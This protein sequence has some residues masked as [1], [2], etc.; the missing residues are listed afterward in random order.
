[1]SEKPKE[2]TDPTDQFKL[3]T[4]SHKKKQKTD[5]PTKAAE[6][7]RETEASSSPK[8]P[9]V[10]V[11]DRAILENALADVLMFLEQNTRLSVA[12]CEF[13]TEKAEI[14]ADLARTYMTQCDQHLKKCE[15]LM[16]S[17]ENRQAILERVDALESVLVKKLEQPTQ[18]AP[19]AVIAQSEPSRSYASII[20]S[21]VA[22]A[23]APAR[24][25]R[26][27]V[28]VAVYPVRP[29]VK[30][31]DET[32][33]LLQSAVNPAGLK[34]T[35]LRRGP[36][37]G[38][39]LEIEG[40][41]SLAKFKEKLPPSLKVEEPAKRQPKVLIYDTPVNTTVEQ[42]RESLQYLVEESPE[43]RD[44]VEATR[45][46]FR[47]RERDRRQNLVVEVRP[48]VRQAI[49]RDGRVFVGWSS[50]RV[51]DYLVSARCFNCQ[52]MG[53]VAKH[54]REKAAICSHCAETGHSYKE[55]T[56][57]QEAPTCAN[58]K[59]WKKEASHDVRSVTCPEAVR[60]TEA[61]IRN[62]EYLS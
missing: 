12:N 35:S 14:M 34:V 29:E 26:R 7:S 20:K 31:S 6:A 39:I 32:R 62:T 3:V 51:R 55:C 17:Q 19:A 61:L 37:A 33:T 59:R 53:H 18:K 27:R 60:A 48:I 24:E 11:G 10:P 38:L 43:M 15:V 54:C 22:R 28:T 25:G 58:C 1:M 50:C 13:L 9:R 21:K 30:N 5:I 45:L 42:V 16:S 56:R 41:A 36:R 4:R 52:R 8:S 57:R 23:A 46:C 2:T 49:L 47:M 44:A 40:E